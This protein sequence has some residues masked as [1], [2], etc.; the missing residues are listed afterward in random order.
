MAKS[1]KGTLYDVADDKVPLPNKSP[2][3]ENVAVLPTVPQ[4]R[5]K[6]A[7]PVQLAAEEP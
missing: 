5:Q 7:A 3:R 4:L 1:S 6:T 2:A